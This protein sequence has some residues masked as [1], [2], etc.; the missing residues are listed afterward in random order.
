[1]APPQHPDDENLFSLIAGRARRA[2]DG[3][4]VTASAVGV[5]GAVLIVLA[6]PGWWFAALPLLCVGSFGIWGI[7]DRTDADR[8]ARAQAAHAGNPPDAASGDA[9]AVALAGVRIAAVVIGTAAAALAVLVI[10]ARVVGRWI[11]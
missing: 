11:S 9:G 7:A 6:S 3:Q 1:V 2:S 10:M 8:T 5:G 4:L